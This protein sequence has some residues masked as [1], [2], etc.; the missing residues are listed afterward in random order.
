MVKL[1][2]SEKLGVTALIGID[3]ASKGLK[4][5]EENGL[6]AISNGI[7]GLV[8][9]PELADIVY[10]ATSAKA[11]LHNAEILKDLGK[12]AIDLPPAAVGPFLVPSVNL[13]ER[14][15]PKLDNVNMVTCG[16]Q[17]T[18]PMVQGRIG[19]TAGRLC[20]NCSLNLKQE[21]RTRGKAEYR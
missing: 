13:K 10:E 6:V 9:R 1:L 19:C 17:A 7:D 3:P 14:E 8:E 18:I 21:C 12:K 16:G 5:A 2:R 4:R 20:R 15:I 11:H